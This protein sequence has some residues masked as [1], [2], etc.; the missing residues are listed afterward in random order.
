MIDKHF[1]ML[2]PLFRSHFN[3][4]TLF[5]EED[6]CDKKLM[7]C[8]LC[9]FSSV[10]RKE[11]KWHGAKVHGFSEKFRP[12]SQ[13][14]FVARGTSQLRVHF[15]TKHMGLKSQCEECGKE[16]ANK[17]LLTRHIK[18]LHRQI[19]YNCKLCDHVAPRSDYLKQ[20]WKFRFEIMVQKTVQMP[21]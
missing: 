2:L 15:E 11:I 5:L 12:C 17:T 6:S 18:T 13:C 4:T 3:P 9:E 1:L 20:E 14:S 16:F 19:K 7:N 21:D 8:A 10:S